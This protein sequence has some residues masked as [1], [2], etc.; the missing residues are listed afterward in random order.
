MRTTFILSAVGLACFGGLFAATQPMHRDWVGELQIGD[1]KHFVQLTIANDAELLMVIIAYPA[2]GVTHVPLTAISSEHGH[3]RFAW[4]D[5]AGPM[6][7]D[8][9]FS[10]GLLAG[11]VQ[12][13]NA[14]GRLQLAPTVTLNEGAEERLLG[15][16]EMQPGHL[17]SILKSPSGL[18]YSD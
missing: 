14:H 13:G 5:H 12:A 1:V 4:V 7:F 17:L 18:V 2:S 15:Y 9:S 10:A 3:V 16:Y 11:G 8:G 6:S